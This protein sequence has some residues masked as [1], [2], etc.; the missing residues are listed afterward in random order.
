MAANLH[1][2]DEP[3][4]PRVLIIDDEQGVT[5][6]LSRI[7]RAMDVTVARDGAAAREALD[8]GLWDAVLCD[9][10]LPD[11]TGA[12]VFEHATRAQRERFLFMTGG[13]VTPDA[14]RRLDAC[15]APILYKPFDASTLRA[16]VDRMTRDV[17]R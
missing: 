15:R 7:L 13:A 3:A 10:T 16:A 6:V 17:R 5:V 9:L 8:D 12:A 2:T 1:D 4:R 14:Q 11:M